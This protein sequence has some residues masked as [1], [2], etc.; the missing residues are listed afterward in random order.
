MRSFFQVSDYSF[1]SPQEYGIENDEKL[2]IGLLTSMPLV[3]QILADV[4]EIE[5][6]ERAKTK[7]Y[8][9]KGTIILISLTDVRI[10]YLYF[11]QLHFRIRD[12]DYNSEK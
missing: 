4:R 12:T 1:V 5:E 3:Q 8:F 7:I 2:D 10:T 6:S 9:T 11:A